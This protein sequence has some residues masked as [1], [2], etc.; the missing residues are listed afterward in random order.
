M[1]SSNQGENRLQLDSLLSMGYGI[2]PKKAM[3]DSRLTPE[4]K[5]IYAYLCSF[6][7]S[8]NTAFPSVDLMCAEIGMSEDRFYRHRKFLVQYGYIAFK[9]I[10][11]GRGKTGSNVYTILHEQVEVAEKPRKIAAPD[12]RNPQNTDPQ[13]KGPQNR[14]PYNKGPQNKGTINNSSTNNNLTNN[15][16][17]KEKIKEGET[18]SL[19]PTDKKPR[20]ARK[21]P[22]ARP[23]STEE[24]AEYISRMGYDKAPYNLTAD[25]FLDANEMRGWKTKGGQDIQDW[26]ACVRVFA[27]NRKQWHT[28][29]MEK[30]SKTGQTGF[31]QHT[32][33]EKSDDW[34]WE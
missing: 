34:G 15:S 31:M 13:N 27:R 5:A 21:K 22:D 12:N 7:G 16:V 28:E 14:D 17:E 25:E 9:Q 30:A 1:S 11:G 24:V 2:I 3:R 4:A 6:A 29:D 18:P 26:K 33:A 10:R 8:G 20:K 23:G 32:E 19:F